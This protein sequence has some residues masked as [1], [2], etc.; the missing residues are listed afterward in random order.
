M[1]RAAWWGFVAGLAT[2]GCGTGSGSSVGLPCD[3]EGPNTCGQ[4]AVCI[5]S[6][7]DG[8]GFE[9][10]CVEVLTTTAPV[11]ATC[12]RGCTAEA[13]WSWNADEGCV[14]AAGLPPDTAKVRDGLWAWPTCVG[15]RRIVQGEGR[16]GPEAGSCTVST[17][18]ETG[19][20]NADKTQHAR[21]LIE[22]RWADDA[23][24]RSDDKP[25]TEVL[26]ETVWGYFPNPGLARTET[27]ALWPDESGQGCRF[28]SVRVDQGA[29]NEPGDAIAYSIRA[30]PG[31]GDADVLVRARIDY[32]PSAE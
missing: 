14:P 24:A 3:P 27:S 16:V 15:G 22:V 10:V 23:R 30:S 19:S 13:G 2:A 31:E 9:G 25:G 20:F 1:N 4:G 11:D 28:W 26:F 32:V 8:T 21:M 29:A 7:G 18:D 5:W 12:R 17:Y 6:A